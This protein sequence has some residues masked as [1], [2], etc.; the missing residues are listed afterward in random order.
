MFRVLFKYIFKIKEIILI[1]FKSGQI[2]L[3]FDM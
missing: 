1:N 3:G 2:T